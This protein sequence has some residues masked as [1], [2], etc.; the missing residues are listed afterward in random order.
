MMMMQPGNDPQQ[1]AD[2]ERQVEKL[3]KQQADVDKMLQKQA[4]ELNA[5]KMRQAQDMEAARVS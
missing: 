3:K 2:Q 4:Q 5:L 1:M